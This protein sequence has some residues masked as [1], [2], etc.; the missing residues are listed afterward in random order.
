ME[1]GDS[2]FLRRVNNALA[3][4]RRRRAANDQEMEDQ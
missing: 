2:A 3:E 4:A 1:H